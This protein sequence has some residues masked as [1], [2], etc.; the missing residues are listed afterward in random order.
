MVAASISVEMI[1]CGEP[2]A[3]VKMVPT[4]LVRL[5][6]L[7]TALLEEDHALEAEGA[8]ERPAPIVD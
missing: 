8:L 7:E 5:G 4:T 6:G 3:E 1:G 2:A